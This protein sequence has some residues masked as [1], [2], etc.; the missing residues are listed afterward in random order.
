MIKITDIR[1][2][3]GLDSYSKNSYKKLA[4]SL[5]GILAIR[6][7]DYVNARLVVSHREFQKA[8]RNPYLLRFRVINSESVLC[9]FSKRAYTEKSLIPCAN[10]VLEYS[11]VELYN[12]YYNRIKTVFRD[13]VRLVYYDT[14]SVF[15]FIQNRDCYDLLK[16]IEEIDFSTLPSDHVLY[17]TRN[18]GVI[19]TWKL[20]YG[21]FISEGIF[22]RS[23][24]YSLKFFDSKELSKSKGVPKRVI[25]S[26]CRFQNY[27]DTLMSKTPLKVNFRA[28]RNKGGIMCTL[29]L[30]KTALS[31]CDDKRY[32]V[33][34]DVNT[35][36]LGHYLNNAETRVQS[37]QNN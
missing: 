13:T 35:R 32:I 31:Y 12:F 18:R 23:K 5:F 1:N 7:Q 28:I 24:N 10:N 20:D 25:L 29:N 14:D 36:A 3:E 34:D 16:S 27:A 19:G 2:K 11:K 33:E 37:K 26:N 8:L 9:Q 30:C 6:R 17:N 22:L 4:N 15:L 21:S